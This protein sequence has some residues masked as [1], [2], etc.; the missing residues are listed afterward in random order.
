MGALVETDSVV[1]EKIQKFTNGHQTKTY[2]AFSSNK[3][4]KIWDYPDIYD[5][6]VID[7]TWL[8]LCSYTYN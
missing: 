1:L 6:Q 8:S 3:P 7:F 5:L 4:I 2:S